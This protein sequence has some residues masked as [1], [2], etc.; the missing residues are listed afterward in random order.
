[1]NPNRPLV[2]QRFPRA[3]CYH[4]EW[5]LAGVSG[6]ANPLW[7]SEWLTEGLE[8]RPGMRV[9]DLGC[10]PGRQTIELARRGHRVLGVDPSDKVLVEAR[11]GKRAHR[12]VFVLLVGRV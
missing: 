11:Q 10:G 12:V 8:L 6:G 9:L 1:M 4:P 5:V 3:S 2:S 7:L